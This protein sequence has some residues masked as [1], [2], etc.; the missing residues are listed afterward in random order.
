VGTGALELLSRGGVERDTD[1]PCEDSAGGRDIVLGVS[2]H[3]DF[4]VP[5]AA[6]SAA[7]HRDA[8]ELGAELVVA[9][10]PTAIEHE[11]SV[12]TSRRELE[13]GAP[14]GVAGRETDDGAASD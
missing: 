4:H 13:R 6:S 12:E 1:R 5:S 2:H 3:D 9:A 7:I 11:H 14:A 8:D 10:V